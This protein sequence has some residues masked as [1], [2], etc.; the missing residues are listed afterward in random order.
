M[1][2]VVLTQPQPRAG[3]I[4][5]RLRASGHEALVLGLTRIVER[6]DD[7]P[8]REAIA[9]LSDFD[10]VVLVSPAAVRVAAKLVPDWPAAV[11]VAVVGPGSHEAFIDFRCAPSRVLA[12]E[13]APY[14]GASLVAR[15][16][17]EAPAAP[18]VLV[19]R[20]E[21]GSEGWIETLRARQAQVEV[22]AA[23][24][25]EPLEP[26]PDA[27]ATLRAWLQDDAPAPFFVVTQV[28]GAGRLERALRDTGLCERALRMPALAIHPR[29]A[30]ALR[31]A[32][33][34]DVRQV[35][36]GE[37]ALRLAIESAVDSSSH[38]GH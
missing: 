32:G 1:A 18:R 35:D 28:A 22:R 31:S 4:A 3:V 20:G 24:R 26:A 12:P 21:T 9:R 38:N 10:W 34:A 15:L 16:L 7:A 33:W 19:L 37:R 14:D 2:R 5:A 29:I 17:R 25:H 13:R 8:L 30:D 36:P 6:L 23:Y 27:L 11:G